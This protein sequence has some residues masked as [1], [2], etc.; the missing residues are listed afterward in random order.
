MSKSEF[1][2]KAT[3]DGDFVVVR[4]SLHTHAHFASKKGALD[5]IDI[6]CKGRLPKSEY[7]IQASKRLLTNDE[8]KALS[9]KSKQ[10]YLNQKRGD[11]NGYKK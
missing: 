10:K 7:F 6:I 8:F 2:V 3:G 9:N 5:L 4:T 11:F 1:L